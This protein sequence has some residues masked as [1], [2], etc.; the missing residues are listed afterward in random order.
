MNE[1]GR[2]GIAGVPDIVEVDTDEGDVHAAKLGFGNETARGDNF[3]WRAGASA[4]L[5]D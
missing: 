2:A 3:Y 1:R 4:G 5:T